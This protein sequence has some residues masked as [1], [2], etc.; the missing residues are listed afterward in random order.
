MRPALPMSTDLILELDL[1]SFD[2]V[3]RCAEHVVKTY[4]SIDV[5]INNAGIFHMAV[6]ERRQSSDGYEEHIQVKQI[7]ILFSLT[8]A[9]EYGSH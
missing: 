3:R 7:M 1:C 5:L 4:D 8:S 6:K 2:S 9:V